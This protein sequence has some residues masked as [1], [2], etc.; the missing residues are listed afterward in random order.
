MV[1]HEHLVGLIGV[2][3]DA[4]LSPALHETEAA[5]LGLRYRYRLLDAEDRDLAALLA[6]VRDAGYSGVNVTHPC[7]Q[8]GGALLDDLSDEARAL[9]AVNPVVFDHGRATGHNT[10][11][12]GFEAS[13]RRGLAGARKERVVVL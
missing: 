7:K 3:I 5:A 8:E 2:G 11:A 4:S 1:K 6:Q 10:D 12:S 13:F 9:D